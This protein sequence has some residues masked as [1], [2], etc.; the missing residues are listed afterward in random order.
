ML[1]AHIVKHRREMIV[2]VSLKLES[3]DA[4][5]LFGASG[6]GKS[7]VLAC[8]AG[9]DEPDE[10]FV[11]LD[12]LQLFPPAMPLHRRPLGYL[13]QEPGLFS[14][15]TVC[16]NVRFGIPKEAAADGEQNRWIETL[17]DQLHLGPLWSAPAALISGGQAR[18][19][20]LARM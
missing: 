8:I 6:A 1:N 20:S 10:G 16:E 13:T 7:T 15:L 9:I 5:G 17:R 12:N 14:H 3:G 19:V 4:L 2:D 18:R 11:K